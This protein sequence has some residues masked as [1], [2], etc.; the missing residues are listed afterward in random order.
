MPAAIPQVTMV[1][2]S[3]S[4]SPDAGHGGIAD[5]MKAAIC[6]AYGPPEVVSLAD[7]PTPT[8]RDDEVL[9]RIAAATV[10]TADWRVR[11]LAVPA[12][13][14]L[15]CRLAFGLTRPRI[16]VLGTEASG[17]VTAVGRDVRRFRPGDAVIV[18]PGPG[19]RCHAEYRAMRETGAI[20]AKP[21]CLTHVESAALSFGGTTALH[22]LRDRGRL[23]RGDRVLIVGARGRWALPPYRSLGTSGRK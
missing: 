10:S 14:R 15:L 6:A 11:A 1:I 21:V 19:L 22:F 9:I 23:R 5:T 16:P 18:Y 2:M 13:F 12:G 3:K 7:I 17:V 4:D 20:I 8:P